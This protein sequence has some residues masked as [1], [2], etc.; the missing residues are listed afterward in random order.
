VTPAQ[1]CAALGSFVRDAS[2]QKILIEEITAYA[3]RLDQSLIGAPDARTRLHH[4]ITEL[5]NQGVVVLP[6]SRTGWDT[7]NTPALP[8]W[9]SKPTRPQP[10]RAAP[11]GRVWPQPLA[12]AALVADRPDE[13]DLLTRIG[14]WM[15][16]EPHPDPVPLEERSLDILNDEKALA[17]ELTKRIFTTGALTL[18]L[19][20][21]Y[22]TPIPFA[23]Q[24]VPGTGPTALLVAENNATYHSLITV[25]R[26]QPEQARPDLH[27]AWGSGSQFPVS[28]AS[29]P[30]L[31]PAP[32]SIYYFGDVDLAGLRI[33]VAATESAQ[34]LGLPRVR[35][36]VALYEH[37]L[38]AG[39]PRPDRSNF[40]ALREFPDIITWLPSHL[41]P[42]IAAL[43]AA[44]NRI[45]Q[46]F[47][48]L[49]ALRQNP[50]LL[51]TLRCASR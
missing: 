43:L 1:L 50:Y 44:G 42:P 4:V 30:L 6:K 11:T 45:P 49:R 16:R 14:D 25:A 46:E 37:A 9:V 15:R 5:T 40:G 7:R 33:A 3:T 20:A 2:K 27:I 10:R 36:A 29:V 26:E 21:A 38:A 32:D 22:R 13:I 23:S 31:D 12:A 48:G 39:T 41:K 51:L 34:S 35:P 8:R 47:V 28:I 24:Y 18:D 19:L 17:L